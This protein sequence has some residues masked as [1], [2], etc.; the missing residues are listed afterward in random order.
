MNMTNDMTNFRCQHEYDQLH[1]QL[2]DQFVVHMTSIRPIHISLEYNQIYNQ[3]IAVP[4]Q[5]INQ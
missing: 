1:D 5:C 3:S 2:H 4:D